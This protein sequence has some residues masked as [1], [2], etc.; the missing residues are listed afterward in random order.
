MVVDDG[1]RHGGFA[2]DRARMG[3]GMTMTTAVS[4]SVVD[5]LNRDRGDRNQ[6]HHRAI[7]R[8]G[9]HAVGGQNH[10]RAGWQDSTRLDPSMLDSESGSGLTCDTTTR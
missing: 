4:G 3:L 2:M 9:D 8:P 1:L 5:G 10:R 6:F 7:L